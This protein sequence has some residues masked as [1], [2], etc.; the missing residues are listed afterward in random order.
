M[1][2][3]TGTGTVVLPFFRSSTVRSQDGRDVREAVNTVSHFLDGSMV[4]MGVRLGVW[5][6]APSCTS[7]QYQLE[8]Q[9]GDQIGALL[10]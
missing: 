4:R 3:P 6:P 1:M 7:R 2:D 8:R 9:H 10:L 5:S